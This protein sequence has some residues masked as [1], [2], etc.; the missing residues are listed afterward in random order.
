MRTV[1][2]FLQVAPAKTSFG[3][4]KHPQVIKKSE[5]NSQQA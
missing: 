3:K 2:Y 5:K 1:V 4:S